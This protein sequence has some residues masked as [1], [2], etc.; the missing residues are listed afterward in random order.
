MMHTACYD[1]FVF[2]YLF[3]AP[4]ALVWAFIGFAASSRTDDTCVR[5]SP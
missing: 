5:P 3:L 4:A 1:V 2:C